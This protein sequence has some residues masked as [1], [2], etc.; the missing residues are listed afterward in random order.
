MVPTPFPP[1]PPRQAPALASRNVGETGGGGLSPSA[2]CL[3][4]SSS[5][6]VPLCPRVA[7][8]C[9]STLHGGVAGLA[10]PCPAVQLCTP[11]EQGLCLAA[12]STPGA[13]P[14]A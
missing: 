14:R 6:H 8:S 5:A 4:M 7:V 3:S 12:S 10:F 1:H 11:G 13:Q 2:P 9:T